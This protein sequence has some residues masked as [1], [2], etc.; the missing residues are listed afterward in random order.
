MSD[1]RLD[2][3]RQKLEE[4]RE[5]MHW[6]REEHCY[7]YCEEHNEHCPYY[8]AEEESYDYDLCFK[9]RGD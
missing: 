2:I 3:E 1:T 9:E 5:Q 8:D 6:A 4:Y 7:R